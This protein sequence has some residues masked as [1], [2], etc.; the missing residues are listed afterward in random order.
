[1]EAKLMRQTCS[2]SSAANAQPSWAVNVDF[3]TPPFPDRT[4]IFRF[5]DDMRSRTSGRAGSGPR[6][7]PDAQISW[8]AHPAQA[9]AFPASS[10]SVPLVDMVSTSSGGYHA[11]YI[12]DSARARLRELR[13]DRV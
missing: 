1:M 9:S 8:F 3:P 7:W 2:C 6:A 4:R 11:G 5:T 10:D 12:P 13:A